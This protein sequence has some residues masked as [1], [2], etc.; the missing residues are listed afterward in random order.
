VQGGAGHYGVF[1]GSRWERE[2]YP[3]LRDVIRTGPDVAGMLID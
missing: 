2:I 1:A 3:Q